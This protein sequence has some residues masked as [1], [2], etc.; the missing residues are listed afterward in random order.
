MNFSNKTIIIAV[1]LLS[2]GC[3]KMVYTRP[4]ADFVT[5][6]HDKMACESM[7]Y[8]KGSYYI[9]TDIAGTIWECMNTLGYA[10]HEVPLR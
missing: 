10:R 2:T 7:A 6:G 3:T 1:L 8:Q 4:G 5:T 9:G